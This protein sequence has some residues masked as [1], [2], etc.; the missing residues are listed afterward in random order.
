MLAIMLARDI[1]GFCA[2]T[3]TLE[4][5]IV[6]AHYDLQF[7]HRES[8]LIPARRSSRGLHHHPA[9]DVAANFVHCEQTADILLA[10][11]H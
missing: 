5:V 9:H 1:A 3:A 11:R 6:G 10:G 8:E 2:E 7:E 4:L